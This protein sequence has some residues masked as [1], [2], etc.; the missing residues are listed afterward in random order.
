MR[1]VAD[2]TG[3]APLLVEVAS[4]ALSMDALLARA[5]LEAAGIPAFVHHANWVDVMP[6]LASATGGASVMVPPQ[7][8]ERALEVL[9]PG[10]SPAN[11]CPECGSREIE[12]RR[13][14]LWP[15]AILTILIEFPPARTRPRNR[16][17]ACGHAWRG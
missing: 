17:R 10:V 11:L 7:E 15:S 14:S 3:G 6:I 8:A 16:C 4:Y 13:G 2:R 5:R 1:I 9:A 12:T